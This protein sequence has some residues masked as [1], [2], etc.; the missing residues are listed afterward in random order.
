LFFPLV[1][2]F[3]FVVF[4]NVF[5][6]CSFCLCCCYHLKLA[7]WSIRRCFNKKGSSS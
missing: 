5:L 1:V 2:L 4:V 3:V 6:C 7:S